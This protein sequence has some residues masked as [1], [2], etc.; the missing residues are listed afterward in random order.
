M[1][2]SGFQIT[3][4][5]LV[6]FLSASE[7][8]DSV[9][10]TYFYVLGAYS[11]TMTRNSLMKLE[12]TK[13]HRPLL[14]FPLFPLYLVEQMYYELRGRIASLDTLT[15]CLQDLEVQYSFL[16]IRAFLSSTCPWI[17]SLSSQF[18]TEVMFKIKQQVSEKCT[19]RR[20]SWFAI[21]TS[22]QFRR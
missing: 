22:M 17:L 9:H 11:L 16:C 7:E 10:V 1:L 19:L 20:S 2:T 18:I 6:L 3:P 12:I 13:S 5:Q 4:A 14:I 15:P 8:I 21:R